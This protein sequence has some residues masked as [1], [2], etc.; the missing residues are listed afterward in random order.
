MWRG[1]CDT[2]FR[3][4]SEDVAEILA[5]VSHSEVSELK[6]LLNE[7]IKNIFV[8]KSDTNSLP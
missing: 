6:E 1:W 8:S 3:T 5:L 4:E 7:R 2:S